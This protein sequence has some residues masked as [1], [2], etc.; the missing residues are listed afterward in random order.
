M[1][2]SDARA[3]GTF[4]IGGDLHVVRLG[5]GAMRITGAGIWGEPPDRGRALATLRRVP[6]LGIDFIDTADS[7]GPFVSEDLIREALFPYKGLVIATKG[8]HTRHGPDIW[9][10]V[11][12]PDYLR[13]CV[14][15]SL[16][17]L[18]LERI[19]LWQLHRV[20][21]DCPAERQFEA[22]AKMREEGLIR[23]VGLSEVDV[24]TIESARRF[25]PVATVQ[26]RFNLVDRKSEDV[27]EHCE[28][29]GIGFI[30]WAPLAAGALARPGSAL[31][32]IAGEKG[33]APGT[34]ALAWLLRRS[35]V[36]L[37]IPGTGSPDHL[38][39]NVRAAGIVLSAHEMEELDRQGRAVWEAARG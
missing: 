38:E 39:E 17:R 26:N 6:E 32:R 8:G 13:Q 24:E 11:G 5:F 27:L 9:R 18:K 30:P 19:D 33:V 7:Y 14:L 21:P 10:P 23:H 4:R 22:I 12:N 28:R 25:F 37:P 29:E 20:G 3:A 36:M 35:S 16:R 15:M 34:V 1:A 2:H 31:D